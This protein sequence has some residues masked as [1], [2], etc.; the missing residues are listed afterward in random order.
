MRGGWTRWRPCSRTSPSTDGQRCAC[1]SHTLSLCSARLTG[2]LR[3]WAV[4]IDYINGLVADE[5][6]KVGVPTPFCDASTAMVRDAGVGNIEPD[7][8]NL[9]EVIASMGEDAQDFIA[10]FRAQCEEIIGAAA[11]EEEAPAARL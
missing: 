7:P 4:Q 1:L 2:G 3:A 10:S 8:A 9:E 6:R 5:G 11:V